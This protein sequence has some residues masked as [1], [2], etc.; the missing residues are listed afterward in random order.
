MGDDGAEVT[1]RLRAGA[2]GAEL[3]PLVYEELRT[4]AER[5]MGRERG[6]H[7][8]QVTALVHEAYLRLVRDEDMR[9]RDRRHFFG[10]AAEAMRRVLVDHARAVKSAKRGGGAARLTL[11]LGGIARRDDPD[12]VLAL[13]EALTALEREDERAAEVARLRVF[14]G[15]SNEDVSRA[16]GLSPRTTARDWLFARARLTELLDP[17]DGGE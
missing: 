15:F 5:R 6:E 1:R 14:S 17:V 11:T 4:L 8:L 13:D 7:T 16:L 9:W 10:A 3:F 12:L 2:N